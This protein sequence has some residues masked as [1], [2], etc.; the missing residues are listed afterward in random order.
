MNFRAANAIWDD[1]ARS[2]D[3]PQ[4]NTDEFV[5]HFGAYR[6]RGILGYTVSLQGGL[7]GYE[8][9]RAS[10][11]RPDGT[12]KPAWLSRAAPRR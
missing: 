7:P 8:G 1:E 6:D 3:D 10:A 12:L 4:A 5:S 2:D 9:A 11:F